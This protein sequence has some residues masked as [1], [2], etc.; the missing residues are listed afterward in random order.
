MS[1]YNVTVNITL[2]MEVMAH[3]ETQAIEIAKEN[4]DIEDHLNVL[5]DSTKFTKAK[6]QDNEDEEDSDLGAPYDSDDE[7]DEEY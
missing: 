6:L 3:S 4:F 2:Q 7:E 1:K 5:D